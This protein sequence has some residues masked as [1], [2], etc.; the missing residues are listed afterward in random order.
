VLDGSTFFDVET[1]TWHIIAQCRGGGGD[2][3]WNLCHYTHNGDSPMST[4]LP[5]KRN[6]VVAGGE[7]WSRICHGSGKA[8]D[9]E[10]T[11]DEGTPDIVF[12]RGGY[13]YVTFHGFNY[14]ARTSYRGVAKTSDFNNWIL[15]APD[16][17]IDAMLGPENRAAWE[18]N[19]VGA[20]MSTTLVVG[21]YQY[22]AFE[23]PTK[24]LICTNGQN[25]E[26]GLVRAPAST[27][28]S[29][30]SGGWQ[31]FP[32]NPLL[33]PTWPGPDSRCEIQYPRWIMDSS[34]VYLL[35]EDWG[36]QMH[37]V[38][39]RLMKLVLGAWRPVRPW[40]N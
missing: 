1:R 33:I 28:P 7:L 37:Y 23:A 6:P 13:F 24:T 40:E 17:P 14:A 21:G 22:M 30:R 36:P 38:K 34:G 9:P 2:R 12:K 39:R 4:F 3:R 25:W 16:L 32:G 26:I 20:G 31:Q 35:Y 18:P 19:C 27:F 11:K 8:C 29:W 10:H 5:D 15:S